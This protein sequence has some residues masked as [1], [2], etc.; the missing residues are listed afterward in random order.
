VCMVT[1]YCTPKTWSLSIS[2]Q[3][4]FARVDLRLHREV[5]AVSLRHFIGTDALPTPSVGYGD[6]SDLTV[7]V[8]GKPS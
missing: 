3:A 6:M 8:E 5:S 1:I 2:G 7:Y 4:R